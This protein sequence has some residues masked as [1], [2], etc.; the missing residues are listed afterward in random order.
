MHDKLEDAVEIHSMALEAISGEYCHDFSKGA[1]RHHVRDM[2]EHGLKLSNVTTYALIHA[3]ELGL[4]ERDIV[5]LRAS[6]SLAEFSLTVARS[7]PCVGK[8]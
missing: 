4:S 7:I 2:I 3:D 5:R 6:Q 1:A 8:F